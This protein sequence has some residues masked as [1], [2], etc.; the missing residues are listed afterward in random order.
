MT[1]LRFFIGALPP[2][3]NHYWVTG[4]AGRAGRPV[5][6]IS[7]A[8]LEFRDAFISH[9]I[10]ARGL[11]NLYPVIVTPK[12]GMDREARAKILGDMRFSLRAGGMPYFEGPVT[13]TLAIRGDLMATGAVPAIGSPKRPDL[14]N[15]IKAVQDCLQH[16][17]V[18]DDDN[19]IDTLIVLRE[20]PDTKRTTILVQEANPS[21]APKSSTEVMS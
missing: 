20:A 17:G 11:Q 6:Y 14:D 8:G 12:S 16:F 19:Q 13:L 15:T 21:E 1:P 2:S 9:L 3:V 18:L 5:R 4:K 7:K 10:E